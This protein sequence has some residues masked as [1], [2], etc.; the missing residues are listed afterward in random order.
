LQHRAV[1]GVRPGHA[2]DQWYS[3]CFGQDVD[4]R[5]LLAAVDG[6]GAGQ[7]APL[8]ARTLAA[9]RIAAVQSSSPALPS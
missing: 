5:S 8:F 4:L 3:I 1:M 7:R 6:T 2:H 9:S